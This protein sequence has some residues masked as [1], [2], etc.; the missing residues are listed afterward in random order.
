MKYVLLL[1]DGMADRP[2]E[3][4]GG[5]T[6]LEASSHP[7]MDYLAQHGDCGMAKTIPDGMPTGSDTANMA[8]MGFDPK[9]FYSG[10]SPL[11]AVSMGID[12]APDAVSF[13]CNLVYVSEGKFPEECT[14]VD[15]SSD[16]ITTEEARELVAAIAPTFSEIGKKYG[17]ECTLYPGISYRHCFIISH[18]VPG[19]YGTPPHDITG[20]PVAGH[21]PTGNYADLLTA[22][23]TASRDILANHPVNAARKARG[24]H[25]ANTAWFWGEGTRPALE[26]FGKKYGLKPGVV[27][28]VDLI[29]GLGMCAGMRT[30]D[31]LGA[32]GAIETNFRGKGEA[33][34]ELLRSGCDFVYIHVESPDECGHHGEAELKCRAIERL[35]KEVLT[36]ILE[37]FKNEPLSVLVMPDHPTPVSVRT[38]TGDPVPFVIW[39][40]DKPAKN[41]AERYTEACAASTGVYLPEGY[42]IM[43]R[44]LKEI[45]A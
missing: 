38:H 16:E 5:K 44:F 32:T 11:E 21:M 19:T 18:A 25:P 6:P 33:A 3:C 20:K 14:M 43:D 31:V 28:A 45:E 2:L 42:R 35:D 7:A 22:L 30:I 29:R 12:L 8:C 37:A 27:C 4:L 13:R 34:I 9:R 36:P 24:L 40:S 26:D 17:M 10:R 39:R 1:G 41:P 23:E 15:Y